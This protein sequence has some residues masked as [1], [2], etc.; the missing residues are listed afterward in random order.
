MGCGCKNDKGE[1]ICDGNN[2]NET[3]SGDTVEVK[4]TLNQKIG[5]FINRNN[6]FSFIGL[7]LFTLL[8]PTVI[9]IINPIIVIIFFNKMVL[10]KNTD[11]VNLIAFTKNKKT[12]K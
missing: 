12:K 8:T 3:I 7:F 11:L 2:C 6:K 9:L 4:R 10:G 5:N 1:P